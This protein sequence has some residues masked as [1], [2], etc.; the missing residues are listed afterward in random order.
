MIFLTFLFS[1]LSVSAQSSS[2]YL[3][4]IKEQLSHEESDSGSYTDEIK[5]KIDLSLK[6]PSSE[7]Y[8][9]KI[10]Q[11]LA[12]EEKQDDSFTD[13]IKQ[14]LEPL[15]EMGAIE[16]VQK[17]QSEL[18][19]KR[20]LDIKSAL[21]F[22]FGASVTR[23]YIGEAA[24]FSTIYPAAFSPDF[25]IHYEWKPFHSEWFGS[26]GVVAEAGL[27]SYRGFGRFK[28]PLIND[29][30]GSE[31][32][33]TSKVSTQLLIF[34]FVSG[35]VYRFNLLR[36]IRPFVQAGPM[37][38]T[39]AESRSDTDRILKTI[40]T[41]WYAS[42]GLSILLDGISREMTW[43]LYAVHTIKHYYLTAE[44]LFARPLTGDI[45]VNAQGV[46]VGFLME[47]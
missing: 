10:K 4:K 15:E 19:L 27:Q 36:I 28:N 6:Q 21:G 46:Y 45:Q 7:D 33:A 20:S 17:G 41:G 9:Q 43:D 23:N 40:S 38:L 2:P 30:T 5:Q 3:D 35:L 13:G 12:P 22:R 42:G 8:T 32:P 29:A 25:T 16:A 31:F 26:L 34:P 39:F 47:M 44:Y 37:L 18:T 1:L 11:S 14:K 24:T